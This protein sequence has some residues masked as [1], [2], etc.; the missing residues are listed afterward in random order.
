MSF[1]PQSIPLTGAIGTTAPE[2]V[3]PTHYDSLGSGGMRAVATLVARDAIPAERR[4]FGMFVFVIEANS[5]YVLANTD[6]GGE[7]D[8]LSN[9]DNWRDYSPGEE[10]WIQ[11]ESGIHTLE[12]VGVNEGNPRRKLDVGLG[13]LEATSWVN[14]LVLD[15]GE[16]DQ[17]IYFASTADSAGN[18]YVVSGNGAYRFSIHKF[19]PSG[20]LIDRRTHSVESGFGITAVIPSQVVV[21]PNGG[22]NIDSVLLKLDLFSNNNTSLPENSAIFY[23]PTKSLL[24]LP[25]GYRILGVDGPTSSGDLLI[26]GFK[27]GSE[28][29]SP[30]IVL[31]SGNSDNLRSSFSYNWVKTYSLSDLFPGE[32]T[33][34]VAAPVSS[35]VKSDS[36]GNIL[37]QS[38]FILVYYDEG[39]DESGFAFSTLFVKFDSTGEELWNLKSPESVILPGDLTVTIE[40]YTDF[41]IN[42]DGS[43]VLFG[44]I[45]STEGVT[46]KLVKVST[47]G[48]IVWEKSYSINNQT[49][50]TELGL[51]SSFSGSIQIGPGGKILTLDTY[52]TEEGI[53]LTVLSEFDSSGDFLSALKLTQESE[54]HLSSAN[55]DLVG[56]LPFTSKISR[57]SDGFTVLTNS[58]YN[59]NDFPT[60]RDS[61]SS[62]VFNISDPLNDLEEFFMGPY[63]FTVSEHQ[64]VSLPG[65]VF[66]DISLTS[67]IPSEFQLSLL[68][69]NIQID[70]ETEF[71][72]YRSFTD[73]ARL[74]LVNGVIESDALS[75]EELFV[76]SVPFR[77]TSSE[78]RNIMI[79]NGAGGNSSGDKGVDNIFIGSES[80]PLNGNFGS[81]NVFIGQY[82]GVESRG[83]F[84]YDRNIV[85]GFKPSFP[86]NSNG[87]LLIGT[88]SGTWIYGNRDFNISIGTHSSDEKLNIGGNISVNGATVYGS[89][90]VPVETFVPTVLHQ[91]FS[92][93]YIRSVEYTV[94]V[95]ASGGK[96][97]V[98]K[99][100]CLHDGNEVFSNQYG[101]L[102]SSEELANFEV[103][104]DNS[105]VKLEALPLVEGIYEYIV[106]F[107]AIRDL[108]FTEAQP[109]YFSDMSVQLY[110]WQEMFFIP[111]WGN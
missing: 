49:F 95:K 100:M 78:K 31:L 72:Y 98:S 68:S 47:L 96:F 109:D 7:D 71:Y 102:Y 79:G 22:T 6:L 19:S 67:S 5:L 80:G 8:N 105:F 25:P 97:Q 37:L 99:I 111:W 108:P 76:N 16:I 94:Q 77:G 36:S 75:T 39:T 15:L 103:S 18:I 87:G 51:L 2:D 23:P 42:S 52:F 17:E 63:R 93:D 28:F 20:D 86:I 60:G 83:S 12:N 38:S 30:E 70:T 45:A 9:N 66:E 26:S 40:S 1:P 104:L 91:D 41:A 33:A 110:G 32:Y 65:S 50:P 101:D 44:V 55:P 90:I 13:D 88:E 43:I 3:F 85:L 84:D 56:G 54:V 48:N 10:L 64:E 59:L 21:G 24:I 107:E 61:V 73:L 4:V 11:N 34:A 58:F 27:E 14:S 92:A 53:P 62:Q 29:I 89:Q 57:S 69:N 35:S 74:T 82:S 81:G 106:R 46:R